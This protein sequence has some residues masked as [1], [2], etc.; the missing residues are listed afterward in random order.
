MMNK[1]ISIVLS[2]IL[3]VT[4]LGATSQEIEEHGKE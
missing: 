1:S 4:F 3:V 2:I